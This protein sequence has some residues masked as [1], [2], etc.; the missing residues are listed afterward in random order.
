METNASSASG[1]GEQGGWIAI[2]R[3]LHGDLHG[4]HVPRGPLVM[5]R[6]CDDLD[7]AIIALLALRCAR[8]RDPQPRVGFAWAVG[9]LARHADRRRIAYASRST[10]SA[11]A[12]SSTW[13]A[14][15]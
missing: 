10:S 6:R 14:T 7:P 3:A 4:A 12:C 8:A 1:H 9:S 15:W 13:A 5:G 2:W 11:S